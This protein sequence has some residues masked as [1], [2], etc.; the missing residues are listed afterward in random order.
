MIQNS[1][2][3]WTYHP[4]PRIVFWSLEVEVVNVLAH[5]AAETTSLV[6]QGAPDDEDSVPQRPVGLN[7]QEALTKCDEARDMENGVGIQVMELNPICKQKTAKKRMEGKRESL[8]KE[9]EEKNPESWRWP[10]YDLWTGGENFRR[11][12]LQQANLLSARQLPVANL[13]LDPIPN[14][15]R[16][17]VGGLDLLCGGTAGG[18]SHGRASLAHNG[19]AQQELCGREGRRDA[20]RRSAQGRR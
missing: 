1:D 19:S 6:M 9:C 5:L 7:P 10:G 14:I 17:S 15:G 12:V 16:V 4:P 11:V 18:T 3:K 20:C 8:E 13:G 2:T